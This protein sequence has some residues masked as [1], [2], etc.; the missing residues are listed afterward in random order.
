MKKRTRVACVGAGLIGKGWA[1][2]F[3]AGGLD[4]AIFDARE[5]AS[6]A[7]L[8]PVRE[9]AEFV[10]DAGLA[11]S[12]SL[13]S[14]RAASTLQDAVEGRS[15]IQESVFES[16]AVKAKVFRAA[17]GLNPK[18]VIASSTSSLSI[19]KIQL[20]AADPSRCV[21]VHPLNPVYI[22]PVVEVVGG[23]KTGA[24]A[25]SYASDL[26]VKVGKVPVRL[27]FE[28]P[29]HILDRLQDALWRE[30]L[31]LLARGVA[32]AVDIDRAVAFGLGP[33][34]AVLGPFLRAHLAGGEGGLG[35]YFDHIEPSHLHVWNDMR[36]WKRA[37]ARGK[38]KA[39]DSLPELTA[40]RRYPDLLR[41]RDELLARLVRDK[42]RS[43]LAA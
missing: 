9:T 16:Y 12:D 41:E 21:S 40:G 6:E 39:L 8:R 28:V 3:L 43:K 26:M 17:S 30:A 22:M 18:A 4:V 2:V 19:S 42:R 23:K 25:L 31:D 20:S 24:D 35:Y 10:R 32:D 14:L 1:S 7:A 11:G 13:G 33:R 34:W 37:P 15:Y 36:T 38:K 29:G 27:N 5:G